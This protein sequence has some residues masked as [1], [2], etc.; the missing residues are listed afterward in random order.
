MSNT[1][2]K[3]AFGLVDVDDNGDAA[4]EFKISAV[5]TFIFSDGEKTLQQFS[6]ADPNQLAQL[7]KNLESQ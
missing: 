4:V 5:P 2:E 7:V 1:T 6:G 3:V